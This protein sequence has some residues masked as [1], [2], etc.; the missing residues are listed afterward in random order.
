MDL[1]SEIALE[2]VDATVFEKV[3]DILYKDG[4]GKQIVFSCYS[5]DM[6]LCRYIASKYLRLGYNSVAEELER[7]KGYRD[8][9]IVFIDKPSPSNREKQISIL[10]EAS[11]QNTVIVVTY[12]YTSNAAKCSDIVIRLSVKSNGEQREPRDLYEYLLS[13]SILYEYVLIK[14]M[15]MIPAIL[16]YKQL[17]KIQLY[18]GTDIEI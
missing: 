10:K 14:L 6:A 5:D 13:S 16:K 4:L 18:K 3:I 15:L 12:N 8:A 9:I 2:Y 7:L 11:M 1:Y 17:G